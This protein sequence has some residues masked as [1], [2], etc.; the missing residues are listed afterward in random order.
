MTDINDKT[1]FLHCAVAQLALALWYQKNTTMEYNLSIYDIAIRY[2]LMAA[3]VITGMF[4][5]QI[6]MTYIA[7]GLFI[8]AITGYCP[9]YAA[10]GIDH[11][12][13]YK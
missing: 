4:T 5:G 6:W 10:L 12:K 3:V 2:M 13:D 8:S 1:D 7:M 11:A 9:I